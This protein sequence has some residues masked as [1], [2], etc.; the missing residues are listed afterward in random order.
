MNMWLCLYV[1]KLKVKMFGPWQ[2]VENV[3]EALGPGVSDVALKS[4][5]AARQRQVAMVIS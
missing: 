1:V 2:E 4:N 3:E 5:S